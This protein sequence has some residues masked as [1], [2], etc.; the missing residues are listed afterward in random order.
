DLF[1]SSLLVL[2]T[3]LLSDGQAGGAAAVA[4]TFLGVVSMV[5]VVP[6]FELTLFNA[7]FMAVI[8]LEKRSIV[9]AIGRFF[10][11][12]TQ[13]PLYSLGFFLLAGLVLFFVVE[14]APSLVG[15]IP[16]LFS[17]WKGPAHDAIMIFG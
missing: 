15:I 5:L 9:T 17:Q 6:F 3:W 14:I 13:A 7:F 16:T 11:L 10:S 2:A 12:L 4:G 8:A 1:I